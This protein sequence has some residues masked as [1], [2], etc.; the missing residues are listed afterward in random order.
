MIKRTCVVLIGM[1]CAFNA[2]AAGVNVKDIY[3]GGGLGLNSLSTFELSDGLGYQFFA[4][5]DLPVKMGKGTLSIEAGYM[6]SGDV[7]FL[8]VPA[9]PPFFAGGTIEVKFKGLWG[10]A[11]YSL[12]LKNNLSL[13]GRVGL[14]IG[15]DDGIMIG[16]G[17]GFQLDKKMEIRAE[18]VIRDIINSLQLNVIMRM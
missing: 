9:L 10:N 5:Y 16:A 2:N 7:E 4:G 8:T 3:F 17:M 13:L 14:D 11:V 1:L 18:Y 6:D 12:P 15:D